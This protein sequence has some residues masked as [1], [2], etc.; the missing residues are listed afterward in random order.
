MP[1]FV[2][3]VYN[4]IA[5]AIALKHFSFAPLPTSI[6]SITTSFVRPDRPN[7]WKMPAVTIIIIV[8]IIIIINRLSSSLQTKGH[9]IG[10]CLPLPGQVHFK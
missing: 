7:N 1:R 10:F 9:A 6:V 3:S 4:T 2:C 5:V 8:I